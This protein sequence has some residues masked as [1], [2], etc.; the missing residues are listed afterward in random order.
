VNVLNTPANPVP[1][2]SV[3]TTAVSGTVS[4]TGKVHIANQPT[5]KIDTTSP[6]PVQ[7]VDNL[8]RNPFSVGFSFQGSQPGGSPEGYN[9]HTPSRLSQRGNA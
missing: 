6:V 8:A 7:D 3:G 1:T 4:M 2:I 5:V 9:N